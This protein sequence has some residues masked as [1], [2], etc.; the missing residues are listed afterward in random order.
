MTRDPKIYLEPGGT[1]PLTRANRRRNERKGLEAIFS[2]QKE[3]MK[4]E[5]LT[6]E[7]GIMAGLFLSVF[8]LF[9]VDALQALGQWGDTI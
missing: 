7:A 2:L 6:G 8:A 4:I 3:G 5:I 1:D 9:R